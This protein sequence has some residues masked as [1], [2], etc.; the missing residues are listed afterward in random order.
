MLVWVESR[1]NNTVYILRKIIFLNLLVETE[2]T[3]RETT[4]VQTIK[5]L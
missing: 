4:L 1:I 3:F 5:P 2:Q